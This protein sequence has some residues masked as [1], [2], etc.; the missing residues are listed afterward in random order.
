MRIAIVGAGIVGVTTAHEL[1]ADGHQLIVFE[2]RGSVAEEAS[3]AHAGLAGAGAALDWAAPGRPARSGALR[4][5]AS[6]WS[7]RRGAPVPVP[8]AG[9]HPL[10]ALTAF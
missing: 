5:F 10:Q 8:V 4:S 2:R 7:S 3:F 6:I 1:A 9:P